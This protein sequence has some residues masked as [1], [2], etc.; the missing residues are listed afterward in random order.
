MVFFAHLLILEDQEHHKNLI[1]SLLFHLRP[2]HKISLQSIHKFLS[3]V[4]YKQTN[5][6][7]NITYF[8]KEVIIFE[9]C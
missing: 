7:E 1:S 9:K 5:A 2:L 4:T 6:T 8:A 3:N